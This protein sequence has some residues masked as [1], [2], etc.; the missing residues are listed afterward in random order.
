VA[1]PRPDG[2]C[3]ECVPDAM[4]CAVQTQG[5]QD[6][7]EKTLIEQHVP[8]VVADDC[9]Y[10]NDETGC[11]SRCPIAVPRASTRGVVDRLYAYA[12]VN[13]PLDCDVPEVPCAAPGPPRCVEGLC[14]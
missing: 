12:D 13:C 9:R 11:G 10:F 2:C 5:Y 7:R 6:F 8:C 4:V 1:V 14:F 3:F